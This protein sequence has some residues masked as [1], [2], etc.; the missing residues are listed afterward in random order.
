[1]SNDPKNNK[2][3][4]RIINI[5]VVPIL[6]MGCNFMLSQILFKLSQM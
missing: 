2:T 4:P 5:S 3:I 6:P 1:M